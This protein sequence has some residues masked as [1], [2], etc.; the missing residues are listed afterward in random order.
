MY[1]L[2]ALTKDDNLDVDA[3]WAVLETAFHEIH[4]KNASKLSYEALF[5]HAY[6]LVLKKEG[7]VLYDRVCDLEANWLQ[8]KVRTRINGLITPSVLLG[9]SGETVDTRSTEHRIAGERFLRALKDAFS[10][11]KICMG[12][13]TDV[14]MYMVNQGNPLEIWTQH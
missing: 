5:R 1:L 4:T 12:M 14:L 10:D 7:D 8:D 3:M 6:K 9:A 11:Q 13:I 2:Q